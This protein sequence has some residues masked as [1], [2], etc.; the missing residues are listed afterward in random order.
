MAASRAQARLLINEGRVIRTASAEVVD[1]PSR[2]IPAEDTLRIDDP[3]RFVSRG[4]EKLQQ[5]IT[6]LQLPVHGRHGLDIGASTGGFTDCLLQNGALSVTA[7]DVGHG[8][9]H[10][11]LQGTPAVISYEGIN[12][13][14]L[15]NHTFSHETFDLITVDVSFISLRHILLP[16]WGFLATG[17]WLAA[18]IKPQFELDRKTIQ[19]CRGVVRDPA[20]LDQARDNIL[21]IAQSSLPGATALGCID[22]PIIGGDGNREFLAAWQKNDRLQ[23]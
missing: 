11:K 1:K 17:G 5:L 9:L 16:A 12:A 18:L 21:A 8:Q 6:T 10:P 15:A 23:K 19:H 14:N 13:R 22:S 7:V 2:K 3:P 20:L 4:G